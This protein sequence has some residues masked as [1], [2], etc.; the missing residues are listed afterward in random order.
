MKHSSAT[1]AFFYG[2]LIRWAVVLLIAMSLSG[3]ALASG[4]SNPVPFVDILSPARVTPGGASFTLTVH[5]ANFISSSVV[6]FGNTSLT[7]TFVNR[8]K[9]TASV[10]ANLIASIGTGWITVVNPTPGG[11]KSNN[12]YLQ[13]SNSGGTFNPTVFS[14]SGGIVN[15]DQAYFYGIT[16]GDLRGD[17][18][19]DLIGVDYYGY[20]WVFLGNGD[21]T[22]QDPVSYQDFYGAYGAAVGDVDG[23]GKPDIVV[24]EADQDYAFTFHKGNG[25]GT[26][27]S[28]TQFGP[29]A[30]V[31]ELQLADMNGDGKLDVVASSVNGNI[32]YVQGNGDS[33]FQNE[34][35]LA[36]AASSP[37]TVAVGDFDG[38]GILDIMYSDTSGS[39][40]YLLKGNGNGTFQ[41]A[42]M[43]AGQ[44]AVYSAATGDFNEDGFLDF[45]G[46]ASDGTNSTLLLNDAGNGFS[47]STAVD[48]G[49]SLQDIAV[50]DLNGDGHADLIGAGGGGLTVTFGKGD[51]TFQNKTAYNSSAY[52]GESILVGNYVAGGGLGVAAPNYDTGG[53][54]LLLPTVSISPSP[55]DFGDVAVNSAA[56]A[57]VLTVTNNTPTSVSITGVSITGA[58]SGDFTNTSTTC[59]TTLAAAASCTASITFTPGAAGARTATFTISDSAAGGMQTAQLTGTG[60]VASA[61]MLTP[62]SLSFSAVLLNT[63]SPVQMVTLKN[64][65]DAVLNISSIAITGANA[66]DFGKT[67]TCG[68]TVAI[69]ATCTIS[70]TFTPSATGARSA[71]VTITDDALDSP[72]SLALSGTGVTDVAQLSAAS[73]TFSAQSVDSASAA[74]TIMLSNV[75]GAS[76]SITSIAVTGTNSGDFGQTN[77]CG[78]SLASAASCSIHVTFTPTAAGSR[79]ATLTVATSSPS[80]PETA[81]LSGT[82]QD[83]TFSVSSPQTVTP[84]ASAQF[85]MTVTPE[86]NFAQL[87]TFTCTNSILHSTCQVVPSSFTPANANPATVMLTVTTTGPASSRVVPPL[88]RGNPRL[89]LFGLLTLTFLSFL[90]WLAGRRTIS[91]R[92]RFAYLS[93]LALASLGLAAAIAG[94][95]STSSRYTPA[96]SYTVTVTATSGGISHSVSAMVT[97]Q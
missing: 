45:V 95:G 71:A 4:A 59:G 96:G 9:L 30:T 14:Y 24:A 49:A 70:V 97:V 61:V 32:Y 72:E 80:S 52:Y 67:T 29:T 2:S 40:V 6:Y 76:L 83:F 60:E 89:Y 17:G 64:T 10:P 42:V 94:C 23:D 50:A 34:V 75:G 11:G 65:G 44:S 12:A 5:G 74:Q 51:G 90:A 92:H 63:A 8:G 66:G 68:A 93:L 87:I 46:S 55:L 39:N 73:L 31:Y 16:Q 22:F 1:N 13:V 84:G 62:A 28:G 48:A 78:S 20:L 7:T 33:T 15:C 38:D 56:P 3:A 86:G 85:T 41:P 81:S 57:M 47:A 25:D 19:L 21:G 35:V 69:S 18:K 82:G 43:Y 37:L 54:D 77:N 91:R 36:T 58:N 27:G 88:H 53:F 26:F 79:S